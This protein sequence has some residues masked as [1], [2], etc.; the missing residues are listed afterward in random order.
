M[1]EHKNLQSSLPAS[2]FVEDLV[3]HPIPFSVTEQLYTPA[4]VAD[5]LG[6]SASRNAGRGTTP[7][8]AILAS[9]P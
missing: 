9:V 8:G 5:R 3:S 4:E 7:L 6:V 2:G 1:R